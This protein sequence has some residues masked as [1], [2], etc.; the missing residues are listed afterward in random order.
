MANKNIDTIKIWAEFVRDNPRSEWIK[1]IKPFLDSQIIIA[2]RFYSNLAK[3]KGG[4][5]KIMLLREARYYKQS[6]Y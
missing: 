5:E 3:T 6:Q 2:N 1:Q 4:T